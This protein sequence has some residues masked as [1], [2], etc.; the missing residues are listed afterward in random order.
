MH[1]IKPLEPSKDRPSLLTVTL[2]I[3]LQGL[4]FT[5]SS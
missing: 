5:I 3:V 4:D 1:P 2:P